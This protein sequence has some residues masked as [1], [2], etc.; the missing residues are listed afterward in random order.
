[1]LDAAVPEVPAFNVA[2][3]VSA[4]LAAGDVEAVLGWYAERDV[5]FRIRLREEL[6]GQA[7]RRLE[8]LGF[9]K[10][11]TETAYFLEKIEPLRTKPAGLVV[12]IVTEGADL[13]QYGAV[14]WADAGL[15]EV[16]IAIAHTAVNLG[17]VLLMG[18]SKGEPVASAMAV[19]TGNIVGIYN[20]A[21]LP[22]HRGRGF[23]TWMVGEAVSAG[24]SRGAAHAY[25]SAPDSAA[26]LYKRLG[27]RPV[28]SYLSVTR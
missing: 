24:L 25:L 18:L 8:S 14:G 5:P 6:D 16:G 13:R 21:V 7:L 3:P 4:S 2:L 28:F 22:C 23:G 20:V 15:A 9:G 12:R 17:F 11:R 19:V 1:M 10:E 27:F 26:G